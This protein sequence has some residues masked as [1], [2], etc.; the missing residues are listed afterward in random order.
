MI[1][2]NKWVGI[3]ISWFGRSFDKDIPG[4]LLFLGK[5]YTHSEGSFY[6]HGGEWV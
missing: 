6:S 5:K 4:Y 1:P 2:G 3:H